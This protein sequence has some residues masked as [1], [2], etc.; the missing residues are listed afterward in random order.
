MSRFDIEPGLKKCGSTEREFFSP[1]AIFSPGR[2]FV[3][4]IALIFL[5]EAF[6]QVSA[7]C[8]PPVVN[9]PQFSGY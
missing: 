2:N 5:N 3:H 7:C 1:V 4:E 8:A 9:C 6:V